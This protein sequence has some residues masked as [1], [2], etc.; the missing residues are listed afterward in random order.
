LKKLLRNF[1]LLLT[2]LSGLCYGEAQEKIINVCYSDW[3]P[4]SYIEKD[5]SKGLAIE[6]Y[7]K[8]ASNAG[9]SLQYTNAPWARCLK[10]FKAGKFDAIAD[11]EVGM[12]GTI[13]PTILPILWVQTFWVRKDSS[14][15]KYTDYSLFSGEIVGFGRDFTYP[16]DFLS[17]NEF[18]GKVP[19][20]N[21]LQGL[22]MLNRKRIDTYFGDYFNASYH[23]E[24]LSLNIR[25][26]LP[27]QVSHLSL[28]FSVKK[29][30][31]NEMFELSMNKMLASGE[32]DELYYKHLGKTYHEVLNLFAKK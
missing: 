13:S 20:L 17:F 25:Y 10:A 5:G 22:K 1:A 11:G 4:F 24:K 26:L 12:Q 27:A 32:I 28:I 19:V 29:L 9:L 31:E 30:Q 6:I 21:D 7:D 2:A 8:A 16:D 18:A 14:H 23:R 15:E 3:Y